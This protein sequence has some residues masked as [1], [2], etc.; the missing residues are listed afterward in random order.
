MLPKGKEVGSKQKKKK[1][2][3]KKLYKKKKKIN[4]NK[5]KQKRGKKKSKA[6]KQ[7]NV[8]VK[9]PEERFNSLWP[10]LVSKTRL[11]KIQLSQS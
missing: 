8:T 4:N 7:E 10:W 5:T 2:N 9:G 1:K 11:I 6:V 3:K